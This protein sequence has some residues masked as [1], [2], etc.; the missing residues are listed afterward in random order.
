MKYLQICCLLAV[1]VFYS[2]SEKNTIR[3]AKWQ[4]VELAFSGPKTS[5]TAADNPFLNY[6]LTV[7]FRKGGKVYL[8]QGFYAADGNAAETGS[9]SG[10]VWKVRF[11]PEEEGNWSYRANLRYGVNIAIGNDPSAGK[12]VKL[13]NSRGVIAVGPPA[14]DAPGFHALGRLIHE[15]GRYLRFLG[16]EKYF[17][18]GGAD[19]PENFLAFHEFDGT[20][21]TG[22][23]VARTGEAASGNTL[24]QYAAHVADWKSGDPVWQGGKGKGIIGALNYLSSKGMNSVYFLTMNIEGDGKD[25]WPYASPNDRTRFDCSKLDQWEIVF[26]HMENLGLMMHLVTQETENELALDSGDTRFERKLYYR[27]L[28]ARFGHHL[29]VVW[30]MGE[31]NGPADFSPKGQ[32]TGQRQEMCRYIKSNNPYDPVVVIHTHSNPKYRYGIFNELLGFE[33]LD[34]PSLQIGNIRDVHSETLVWIHKSDSAGNPWVVNLDEIGPAWRGVDP[35]AK[36]NNN[37]DSVRHLALWGNLMAGGGGCEWYFGYRNPHNDL[38]MEDWRSRE[39]MWDYTRYALNFFHDNLP[40]WEMESNDSLVNTEGAW[41]FAKPGKVYA[42]YLPSASGETL[43]DLTNAEGQ[44]KIQ[45][46]DP[47]NG[48]VMQQ[49]AAGQIEG[50]ETRDVGRPPQD[51]K[52]DWV[53][54]VKRI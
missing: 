4:K 32:T 10:R 45:W 24:H 46:Y 40:F 15:E 2:C 8:V 36:E 1:S 16:S 38:T 25:V 3:A 33:Y 7:E 37:Q 51:V 50:G 14:D 43:L 52:Q 30:N 18:K 6:R 29:A 49:G 47:R 22:V 41:C 27:E 42:V 12:E 39:K 26:D 53:L 13:K 54:L 21:K 48:G 44:F 5:E 17:L 35:D 11:M 9:E 19:S 20:Y 31:E 28:I 23:D 34:G